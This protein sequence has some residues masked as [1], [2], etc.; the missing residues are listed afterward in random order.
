MI[1]T[2]ETQQ[3]SKQPRFLD[4]SMLKREPSKG[5]FLPL[6]PAKVKVPMKPQPEAVTEAKL[7]E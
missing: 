5:S 7:K 4:R 3:P 1:E 6:T 2:S